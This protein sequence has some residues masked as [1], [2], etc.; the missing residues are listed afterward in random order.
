MSTFETIQ[1]IISFRWSLPKEQI[2]PTTH[3][4]Q[5]L[6]FDSLDCTEIVMLA[7]EEY[8]IDISDAEARNLDTVQML[9]DL[10]DAECGS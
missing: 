1:K 8:G 5:D 4:I 3:F 7:E 2:T 10:I 6:R 9:A